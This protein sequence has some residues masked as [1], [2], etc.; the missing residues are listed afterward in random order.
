MTFQDAVHAVGDKSGALVAGGAALFG[1][2][3]AI[4]PEL[5]E[6]LRVLFLVL[7]PIVGTFGAMAAAAWLRSRS[8]RR[9]LSAGK[10][11]AEAR[12]LLVDLDPKNDEE[13]RALLIEA[14]SLSD[15]ADSDET[16]ADVIER[17]KPVKGN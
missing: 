11:R 12:A 10:M 4:P 14:L 13:A 2:G 5:A 7:A 1:A 6:G 15:K 17:L 16:L 3:L 8:R 9:R